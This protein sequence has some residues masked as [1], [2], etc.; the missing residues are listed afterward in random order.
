MC[1]CHSNKRL[2]THLRT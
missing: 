1:D 2:L